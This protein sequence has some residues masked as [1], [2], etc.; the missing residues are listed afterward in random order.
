MVNVKIID[1]EAEPV[2]NVLA[3]KMQRA[4]DVKIATAFAK[5]SGIDKVAKSVE[6]VLKD[7]GEVCVVYGLDFRITDPDAM[8][9]FVELSASYENCSQYAYSEWGLALTHAFHP[10]LYILAQKAKTYVIA[11]SSNLTGGGLETNVEVNA[12]VSGR[13]TEPPIKQ[14]HA[15]F[16][17]ILNWHALFHPDESY[18]TQYEALYKLAA[19]ARLTERPST[20]LGA[21][22]RDLK[23]SEEELSSR[24]SL[25]WFIVKSMEALEQSIGVRGGWIRLNDIVE[26][27]ERLARQRNV[28]FK[29]DTFHNTV[30]GRFNTQTKG[31]GGDDLFERKGG[32]KGREG[33][34]RLTDEGRRYGDRW[35]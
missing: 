31:K 33:R 11:G 3:D 15:V 29:W 27:A 14:A 35:L 19:K 23:R 5:R 32:V 4:R 17:R 34:Y 1:N 9:M 24:P 2:L 8:R 21:E 18:I 30:R 22:Y 13:A 6:R 25:K 7:G 16:G 12:V 10:K 20:R 26:E 28:D